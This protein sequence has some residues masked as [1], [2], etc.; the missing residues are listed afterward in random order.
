MLAELLVDFARHEWDGPELLEV[1]PRL[2]SLGHEY[3]AVHGRKRSLVIDY[4][5]GPTSDPIL[6]RLCRFLEGVYPV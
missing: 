5:A 4:F 1:L 3:L 6:R 2:V